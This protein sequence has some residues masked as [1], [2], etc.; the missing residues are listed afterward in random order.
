VLGILRSLGMKDM[1]GQV[2]AK[3]QELKGTRW[4]PGG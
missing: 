4:N 3:G 1:K 2:R